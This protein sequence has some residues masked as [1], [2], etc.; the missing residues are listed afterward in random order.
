[1]KSSQPD[2][3]KMEGLISKCHCKSSNIKKE[4]ANCSTY[5]KGKRGFCT[6]YLSSLGWCSN[7]DGYLSFK[8]ND[9]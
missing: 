2:L 5:K 7:F 3:C 4:Q 1:M 6:Y 8:E 9:K